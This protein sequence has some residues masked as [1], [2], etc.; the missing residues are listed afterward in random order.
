METV[1][2]LSGKRLGPQGSHLQTTY[3]STLLPAP[4]RKC[5]GPSWMTDE[6]GAVHPCCEFM[7]TERDG[8]VSCRESEKLNR[9][10]RR[11]YGGTV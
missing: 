10:W 4:C 11:R 9:E 2:H 3:L 5:G 7:W 1:G 6:E 8:C